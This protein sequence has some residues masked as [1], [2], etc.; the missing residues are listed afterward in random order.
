MN[1]FNYSKIEK[2]DVIIFSKEMICHDCESMIINNNLVPF[3][4]I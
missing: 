1:A 4:T 3:C 2:S